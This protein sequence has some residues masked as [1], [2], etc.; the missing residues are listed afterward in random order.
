MATDFGP[1]PKG[2]EPKWLE[3]KW[4]RYTQTCFCLFPGVLLANRVLQV[5][6]QC[7][8]SVFLFNQRVGLFQNLMP[9]QGLQ[10]QGTISRADS[11]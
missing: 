4:L 7:V 11:E 6:K 1:A 5:W 2:L 10:S 3:P 8:K 9:G